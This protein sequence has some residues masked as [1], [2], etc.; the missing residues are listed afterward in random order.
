LR[1][2]MGAAGREH[3]LQHYTLQEQAQKLA[4]AIRQVIGR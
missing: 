4:V 1:A 3:S 2:S